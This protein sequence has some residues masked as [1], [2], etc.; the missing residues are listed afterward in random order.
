M[1]ERERIMSLE[2][3]YVA[4]LDEGQLAKI[5]EHFGLSLP[6]DYKKSLAK[7]NRGKPTLERFDT[8]RHKECVLDY[9]I[10][11]EET[12]AAAQAIVAEY[13]VD[14]LIPIA[15]DPFGNLIAFSTADGQINAVVLWDH[16]GNKTAPIAS[17]FTEFLQNLY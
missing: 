15:R 2:W 3:K 14:N 11:L 1:T 6:E 12:V 16:E 7:C 5:E 4:P 10:D 9:M 8:E 17:S 13:G